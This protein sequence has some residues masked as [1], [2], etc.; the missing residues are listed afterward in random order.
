M[1][2]RL[3]FVIFVTFF[4]SLDRFLF[5]SLSFS[6]A[7]SF[8]DY[9]Y[10]SFSLACLTRAQVHWGALGTAGRFM[11]PI[12]VTGTWFTLGSITIT[13]TQVLLSDVT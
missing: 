3:I 11:L 6:L 1:F 9:L 2:G 7:F 10:S 12:G 8:I 13:W 5:G 4:I